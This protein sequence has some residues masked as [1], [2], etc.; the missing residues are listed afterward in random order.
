MKTREVRYVGQKEMMV[1][2]EEDVKAMDEV[3]VTG[4]QRIRKSDM[5]GS[6]I[7]L[8]VKI[9]FSMERIQLNRCYR[10]NFREWWL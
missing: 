9:C 4:Y 2:M 5:V 1:L 7:P 3:I 10:E 8:S 6:T